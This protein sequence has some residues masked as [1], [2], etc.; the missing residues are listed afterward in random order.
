MRVL[1]TGGCGFIG[2]AL[3]RHLVHNPRF[4]IYNLDALTYAANVQSLK[5]ID[6]K[7]NYDFIE[8]NICDRELVSQI[9]EKNRIEGI[10]HL[11]AESHVDRSIDSP[12]AFLKTNIMGTYTLLEAARTY[13]DKA[14]EVIQK[15]FT[16]LHV[17]TDEV[18][19][20]LE[21]EDSAF[22]ETTAYAPSSPYSASK[23]ASDHLVRAWG[24]TFN[25][26]IKITN[27]SNNYG[28]YQFPEKL[29]P[30]MIIEALNGN[31]LPVY[32]KG[33]N[34][35]DWLHVDDH[36]KAL[37]KVFI[38]GKLGQTYN[39][40]G[41]AERRN[42]DIVE[43]ICTVLNKFKPRSDGQS[44]SKQIAFVTDRLGH[45][46]R[47]AINAGKIATELNWQPSY[48]FEDGLQDTIKWYL[49]NQHWWEAF[50]AGREK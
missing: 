43:T 8:G 20:D 18:F 49:E 23:A 29:I 1:V 40:G 44:Y 38:E 32:G 31:A 34:I 42:I 5:S 9:L 46:K 15:N 24:R 45:D 50:L 33:L 10:I 13:L 14:T 35:R 16:F 30:L 36:V 19:G 47:Y 22:T 2:S 25:L 39:I 7:S 12:D 41:N 4:S 27:C 3:C 37:E 17:S 26:P 48:S 28:P 11:A 21:E 6:G